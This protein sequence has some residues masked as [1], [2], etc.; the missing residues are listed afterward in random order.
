MSYQ[1]VNFCDEDCENNGGTVTGL[2]YVFDPATQK[3]TYSLVQNS[4]IFRRSSD[5]VTWSGVSTYAPVDSE[6]G[7]Y[8]LAYGAGKYAAALDD[9]I[10]TYTEPANSTDPGSW[11]SVTTSD[12]TI[13]ML[14]GSGSLLMAITNKTV[15][16]KTFSNYRI[17]TS[18]GWSLPVSFDFFANSG[19]YGF[20]SGVQNSLVLDLI[21]LSTGTY[22]VLLK[23][24]GLTDGATT[25]TSTTTSTTPAYPYNYNTYAVKVFSVSDA[26]VVSILYTLG[27]SSASD[28]VKLLQVRNNLYV[29]CPTQVLTTKLNSLTASSTLTAVAGN[30]LPTFTNIT[31]IGTNGRNLAVLNGTS[32]LYVYNPSTI[33]WSEV[34]IYGLTNRP[35]PASPDLTNMYSVNGQLFILDGESDLYRTFNLASWTYVKNV[36]IRDTE[37]S[38]FFFVNNRPFL[39]GTV[40][41]IGYL[42]VN[43]RIT[44]VYPSFVP[45]CD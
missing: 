15:A 9:E 43:Q 44:R 29:A 36:T 28:P 45:K 4:G 30:N 25:T 2:T 32:S 19:S 41:S 22:A 37:S 38:E 5:G 16:S 27:F 39:A 35:T 1:L 12:E 31:N 40:N 14:H 10:Y 8:K 33:T 17:W 42:L 3:G 26:G 24:S 11:T 34:N 7:T 18:S 20:T 23:N 6:I 13:S 21:A